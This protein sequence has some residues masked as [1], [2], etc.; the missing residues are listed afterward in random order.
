[1]FLSHYFARLRV[2]A[3]WRLRR[4]FAL[5]GA[6]WR[7]LALVSARW[8]SSFGVRRS[9]VK[10]SPRSPQP[11]DSP[12]RFRETSAFQD[13]TFEA[14]NVVDHQIPAV[15]DG[16]L[17]N[18]SC[19][20]SAVRV[21]FS[22]R[23]LNKSTADFFKRGVHSKS[24]TRPGRSCHSSRRLQSIAAG[25]KPGPPTVSSTRLKCGRK[26][27]A[28]NHECPRVGTCRCARLGRGSNP[29]LP[30]TSLALQPLLRT[31]HR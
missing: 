22:T 11:S 9:L 18:T 13:N 27:R 15:G 29:W 7:S 6:R 24:L 19:G 16:F 20:C 26:S 4:S 28:E 21:H 8:C 2:C 1:M 17:T 30:V 10:V 25:L 3:L 5:V 31:R 12:R 14:C 23:P